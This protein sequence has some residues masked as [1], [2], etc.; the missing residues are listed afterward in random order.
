[1]ENGR[2]YNEEAA[3]AAG[4]L[5]GKLFLLYRYKIQIDI[6]RSIIILMYIASIVTT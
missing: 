6:Y 5:P 3:K 2:R 4:T 1:M